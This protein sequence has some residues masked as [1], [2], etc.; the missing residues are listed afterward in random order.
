MFYCLERMSSCLMMNG[1]APLRTQC[2]VA[3]CEVSTSDGDWEDKLS[4]LC[5]C[6]RVCACVCVCVWWVVNVAGIIWLSCRS[7]FVTSSQPS[8]MYPQIALPSL[9][10]H[11]GAREAG[12]THPSLGSILRR[13]ELKVSF[14]QSTSFVSKTFL[15]FDFSL[16][17]KFLSLWL[18]SLLDFN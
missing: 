16:D 15:T 11:P 2:W 13:R 5:V 10:P 9:G 1:S 17:S 7:H 6:V 14:L 8:F 12:S 3:T 18:S 4:G